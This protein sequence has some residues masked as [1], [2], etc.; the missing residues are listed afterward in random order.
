MWA[1]RL[2]DREEIEDM[3]ISGTSEKLIE[4]VK[5]NYNNTFN[6]IHDEGDDVIFIHYKGKEI[7]II[8][9]VQEIV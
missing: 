3:K 9:K 4:F 6:F 8:G 1:L 5:N 2:H 7:G